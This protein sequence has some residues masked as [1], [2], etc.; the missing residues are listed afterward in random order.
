MWV[1]RKQKREIWGNA[2]ESH[3]MLIREPWPEP[4]HW[5]LLLV[6]LVIS[7]SKSR[8][9]NITTV[10]NA[11]FYHTSALYEAHSSKHEAQSWR[12]IYTRY[13]H[14]RGMGSTL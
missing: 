14:R 8:G 5:G 2:V 4:I 11:G 13:D 9:R 10:A 7:D 3:K 1:V 6:P 12:V